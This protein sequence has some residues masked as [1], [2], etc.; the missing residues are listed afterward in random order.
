LKHR[1]LCNS[2][3][4]FFELH[5]DKPISIMFHNMSY[6]NYR[7]MVAATIELCYRF[8]IGRQTSKQAQP[9]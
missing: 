7:S 3:Q 9:L 5:P 2:G 6:A 4:C 1:I 8:A